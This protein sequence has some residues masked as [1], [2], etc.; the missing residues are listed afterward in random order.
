M[1]TYIYGLRCPLENKIKYIGKT[2]KPTERY[3]NHLNKCRDKNTPKRNWLNS[4]RKQKLKPE[5]IILE[6]TNK[7]LGKDRERYW[8]KFY[9]DKG[10][11]LVNCCCYNDGVFSLGNKTSFKKGNNSVAIVALNLDGSF[12]KEFDSGDSANKETKA[13]P[14]T[15]LSGNQK[16]SG[17]FIWIKKEKYERMT[18]KELE[19]LVIHSNSKK[20]VENNPSWFKKGISLQKGRKCKREQHNHRRIPILMLNKETNEVIKEF[21]CASD[22]IRELKSESIRAALCGNCKTA[23]GYKW[24]HKHKFMENEDEK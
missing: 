13:K 9:Y 4:L 7:K 24:V 5:F 18:D 3:K 20:Q 12:Y 21:E 8:I 17:G 10:F 2:T 16:T 14:F 15:V 19:E 1:N 11:D 23:V 22:A 6:E